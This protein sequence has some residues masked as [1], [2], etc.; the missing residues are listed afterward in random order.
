MK[1]E[2]F[3]AKHAKFWARF[4]LWMLMLANGRNSIADEA[5][6]LR[7]GREFPAGY[8]RVC[9]HLSLARARRYSIGLQQRLN[10][11]AL[12]GH[13]HMYRARTPV[14]SAI[15]HFFAFGLPQAFRREWRY[16]LVASL[17]FYLPI[18]AM[19]AAVQIKPDLIYSLLDPAQVA[20][21]EAMYDPANDVLGRERESEQD[22]VMFGYYI[23]N[24]I[25]IGFRTFA[26]GLLF[27]VGSIFFLCFNGLFFGAVASH[28]TSAGFIETFWP[29]VSGH[30]AFELT[31]IAIFG[32]AGLMLGMAALAPKQKTRWHAIRDRALDSMP[33]VYGA[34]TMLVLAAFVEAFWSSTTWPPVELKYVVGISLW[35]AT[36]AYFAWMGGSNES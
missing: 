25:T 29:F 31:A 28:L 6:L 22:V 11:M 24:N 36:G 23:M 19:A 17:L 2:A 20:Q 30:S 9:H 1:Q 14:L 26:G 10:K 18:L 5:D 32:G 21:M 35:L 27:G 13:Q 12:D 15:L 4:E 33:L 8:R 34:T 3:E 16:M 7:V